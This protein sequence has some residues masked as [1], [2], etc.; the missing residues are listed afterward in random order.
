MN[1]S[2]KAT[3]AACAKADLSEFSGRG[4]GLIE[5]RVGR[6]CCQRI[7]VDIVASGESARII[8]TRFHLRNAK[9]LL[10]YDS[11]TLP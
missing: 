5:R 1:G 4:C 10:C 8:S 7:E 2:A 11:S 9:A 3:R 6:S